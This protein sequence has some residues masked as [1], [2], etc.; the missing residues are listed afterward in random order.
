MKILIAFLSILNGLLLFSQAPEGL[1]NLKVQSIAFGSCSKQDFPDKQL[2]KEVNRENPDLWIWLGDNIYGDSED[3]AV[4]KEK[5]DQQKSHPDY[6]TLMTQTEVIGIWDDHDYGVNDGGKEYPVKEASRDLMFDFLDLNKDHPAWNREGGYQ[7]HTFDS[8]GRRIK[9]IFLDARYFRDPLKKDEKN[10]NI[11]NYEGEILGDDQWIWLAQQL[12][13]P[14]TDFFIIGSGIQVIPKDHRFEKWTNFPNERNRLFILIQ[15]Y[16][17]V[18]LIFISG[19]R[20]ISEVSKIEIPDHKYPLYDLTS[21]SLTHGWSEPQPEKN[22]YRVG[23]IIY[24]ENFAL[25]RIDW[26][27]KKPKLALKYIGV[28]NKVLQELKIDF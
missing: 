19:D 17:E 24:D 2:W 5:Y 15:E 25:L 13:D 28:E 26:K 22:E 6:Q 20:H 14:E 11:P 4:L 7:A 9:F 3:M 8:D 18:P 16:V 27:G 1:S 23:D 10:W 12:N 21:S